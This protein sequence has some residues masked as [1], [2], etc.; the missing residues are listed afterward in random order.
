[1]GSDNNFNMP[2]S[3]SCS[4]PYAHHRDNRM[5]HDYNFQGGML[6]NNLNDESHMNNSMGRE[7][8]QQIYHQL[9]MHSQQF[10]SDQ[11][12]S[13][14]QHIMAPSSSS[15]NSRP[16]LQRSSSDQF[17]GTKLNPIGTSS[18]NTNN[19]NSRNQD[20]SNYDSRNQTQFL[21]SRN[22]TNN[23]DSL[24]QSDVNMNRGPILYPPDSLGPSN[25]NIS[26]P[27]NSYQANISMTNGSINNHA[28]GSGNNHGNTSQYP[29][30][31]ELLNAQEQNNQRWIEVNIRVIFYHNMCVINDLCVTHV[32]TNTL[33]V[34]FLSYV[35]SF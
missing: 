17:I 7:N 21:Y 1:M 14:D 24:L 2:S 33:R 23:F 11:H 13:Y 4:Y 16:V 3:S 6:Q 28:I 22:S 34:F 15:M 18:N 5:L 31:Q 9:P 30:N 20:S 19:Y 29:N 12:S 10:N 26:N 32:Y 35:K 8:F 27:F 25:D